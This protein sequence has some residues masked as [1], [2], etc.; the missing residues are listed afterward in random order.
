M[1]NTRRLLRMLRRHVHNLPMALIT[2]PRFVPFT[3]PAFVVDKDRRVLV[4]PHLV[5]SVRADVDNT[6]IMLGPDAVY[7]TESLAEV[8]EKL[9]AGDG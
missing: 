2:K 4:A 7:V 6:V 1:R 9:T 8:I 5:T 3:R